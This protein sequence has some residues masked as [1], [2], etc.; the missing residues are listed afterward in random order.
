MRQ[1][2]TFRG[3]RMPA[4]VLCVLAGILLGTG[5]YTVHYADSGN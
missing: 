4:L 5:A 1:W 3:L 2:I